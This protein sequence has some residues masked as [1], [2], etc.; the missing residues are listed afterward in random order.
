MRN[1]RNNESKGWIGILGACLLVLV[2]Y[3]WARNP[4]LAQIRED[5]GQYREKISPVLLDEVA[6]TK[7]HPAYE[8]EIPVI[9]KVNREYFEEDFENRRRLGRSN[10]NMLRGIHGYSGRQ[11]PIMVLPQAAQN[12]A[13]LGDCLVLAEYDLWHPLAQLPVQIQASMPQVLVGQSPQ[14]V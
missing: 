5:L 14:A 1:L 3:T 9:V 2:S 13:R 11:H 7:I 4:E 12:A 6:F 10:R 8:R